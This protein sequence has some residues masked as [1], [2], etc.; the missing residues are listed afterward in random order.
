MCTF[1]GAP[2]TKKL[3]ILEESFKKGS[4]ILKEKLT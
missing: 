1:L 4:H 2:T 3:A